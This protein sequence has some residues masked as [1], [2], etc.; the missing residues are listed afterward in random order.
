MLNSL[1]QDGILEENAIEF[2][3]VKLPRWRL[4]AGADANVRRAVS[5][6][7]NFTFEIENVED[8]MILAF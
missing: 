3:G 6:I 4:H 7:I 1:P 2:G 5:T 8:S